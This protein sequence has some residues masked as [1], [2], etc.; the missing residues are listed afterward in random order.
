MGSIRTLNQGGNMPNSNNKR[1]PSL[2]CNPNQSNRFSSAKEIGLNHKAFEMPVNGGSA[3][4]TFKNN[5]QVASYNPNMKGLAYQP[6]GIAK[7]L[8]NIEQ[9]VSS[10]LLSAGIFASVMSAGNPAVLGIGAAAAAI[11]GV[12]EVVNPW[13]APAVDSVR[14]VFA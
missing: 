11:G 14:N 13:I 9:Q 6:S 8:S 12:G 2:S 5:I 7:T 10:G 1:V 3:Y 4:P